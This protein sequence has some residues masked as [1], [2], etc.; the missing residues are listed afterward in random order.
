[1]TY[2]ELKS[3][4]G[5]SCIH[6]GLRL[7]NTYNVRCSWWRTTVQ[8]IHIVYRNISGLKSFTYT[9][10]IQLPL[11]V[12]IYILIALFVIMV[13]TRDFVSCKKRISTTDRQ[14]VNMNSF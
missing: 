14:P 9:R 11:T 2:T 12:N 10:F 6:I 4:I 3:S 1:M 8:N 7:V 13:G 5:S